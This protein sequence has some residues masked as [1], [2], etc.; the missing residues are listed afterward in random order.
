M[1]LCANPTMFIHKLVVASKTL[2]SNKQWAQLLFLSVDCW[3]GFVVEHV[4]PMGFCVEC[5]V[6]KEQHYVGKVWML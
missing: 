3:D 5:L 6:S 2:N 1:K 4:C